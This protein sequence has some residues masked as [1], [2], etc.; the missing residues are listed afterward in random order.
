LSASIPYLCREPE[1]LA[2]GDTRAWTRSVDSYNSPEWNLFYVIRNKAN[3]YR[4]NA[5]A[6]A[7]VYSVLLNSNVT[8]NWA[9]GEYAIGAYVETNDASQRVEVRCAFPT[10]TVGENLAGKPQG[11]DPRS[12]ASQQLALIEQ[13]ISKLNTRTISSATLN[14]Q[15]YSLANISE[16]FQMREKFKSEVRREQYQKRLDAGLG[17]GNKIGVR[18]RPMNSVG[19]PN[20]GG[21]GYYGQ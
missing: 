19:W 7:G 4:F 2:A 9:A 6:N 3:F 5:V 14:G 15:A 13:T 10:L 20:S 17:A 8:A 16:L 21:Y 1:A 11:I 12:W 18:F